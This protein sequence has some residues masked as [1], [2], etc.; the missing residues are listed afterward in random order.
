MKP[1][2]FNV[3]SGYLGTTETILFNTLTGAFCV[4]D[5]PTALRVQQLSQPA[6]R[7][8]IDQ[9]S[10]LAAFLA[11]KG[12]LVAD[13][14][15]ETDTVMERS[16]LGIND[17]NRLDVIVMPNMNCNLAC[18]YCYESH[19]KSEMEEQTTERLLHWLEDMIPRFKVV[20]LSWFGGE[21]L[22]SYDT[23]VRVQRYVR[24]LCAINNVGFSSHM[25]TNAFLLSSERAEELANLDLLSYQVTLDGKGDVHNAMRPQRG[26]G[27]SFDR[28]FENVCR[29]VAVNPKVRVTLRVNYNE[30]NLDHISELLRTIPQDARSAMD[31]VFE[32]IFGEQY[33][34]FVDNMPM[35]RIGTTLE[36]LYD[37]AK[38]LGY[39]VTMNPLGPDKLTYCYADRRSMFLINYNGDVFKCTVDRFESKDRLGRLANEGEI[40]W[41]A[42]RLES[43]HG[44]PTFEEKCHSCTFMPMCMGGCR[45]LRSREGTVGDDCKLPFAGFD[46]RL[47]RRLARER[48][49][50]LPLGFD[51]SQE[52]LVQRLVN[53]T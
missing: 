16:R 37:E 20:L 7:N 44:V 9:D 10:E 48:G 43:W 22:L 23:V 38:T 31:V 49:D 50:T 47:Q 42:G 40:I 21:P 25:T 17:P 53:I 30:T 51:A 11:E 39:S 35:R 2:R 34:K 18:V 15:D 52:S 12:F 19:H 28:I 32:R 14:T 45:K 33:A 1:S 27:A 4:F 26:G 36:K 5:E 29:L 6:R 46:Q 3:S 24:H 8:A 41:E 13:N